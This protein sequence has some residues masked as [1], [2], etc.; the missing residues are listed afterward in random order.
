MQHAAWISDVFDKSCFSDKPVFGRK[1]SLIFLIIYQI[2]DQN[3]ALWSLPTGA[4]MPELSSFNWFGGK[5]EQFSQFAHIFHTDQTC[6]A[7]LMSPTL[8][9][10]YLLY[11]SCPNQSTWWLCRRHTRS[12]TPWQIKSGPSMSNWTQASLGHLA[13]QHLMLKPVNWH[14]YLLLWAN[15]ARNW[16]CHLQRNY[17][18]PQSSST[19][20]TF[21]IKIQYRQSVC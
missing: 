8:K 3:L 9:L 7:S 11:P 21:R 16:A 20:D 6:L 4:W 18:G 12:T 1:V 19:E 15:F 17:T 2:V 10:S 13:P 5:N 14:I